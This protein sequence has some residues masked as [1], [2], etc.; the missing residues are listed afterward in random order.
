[1]MWQLYHGTKEELYQKAA[2][3]NERKLDQNLMNYGGMDHDSGFK[4]LTTSVAHYRLTGDQASKNRGLLAAAN[5]AGRFNPV[6]NF[7]RAWNDE[8]DGRN[9]GW[10]II[11]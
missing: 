11:G 10:A 9:A 7:I 3:E 5:L 4:W 8:G 2:L 1:M 6:G